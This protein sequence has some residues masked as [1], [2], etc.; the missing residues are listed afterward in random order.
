LFSYW[1]GDPAT[2]K[3]ATRDL[4]QLFSR[5]FDYAKVEDFTEHDLRHE[6]CCRWF[7]L[8]GKGGRWMFSD[9]EICRIMG[10]SNYSMVLRYASLRGEDLA[11]RLSG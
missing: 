5:L 11:A 9:V 2:K 6:A 8:R 4:V 10:W 1:D 7:E 3:K